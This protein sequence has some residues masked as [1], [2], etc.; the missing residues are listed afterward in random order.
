MGLGR[1]TM[2]VYSKCHGIEGGG[3]D[4]WGYSYG[5]GMGGGNVAFV[6]SQ[7]RIWEGEQA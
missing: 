6:Q 1:S 5:D 2:E 7:G 3:P 4:V